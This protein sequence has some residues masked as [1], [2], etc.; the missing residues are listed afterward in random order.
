MDV[1]QEKC[2]SKQSKG[3]QKLQK[4]LAMMRQFLE[5]LNTT[6]KKYWKLGPHLALDE[7]KAK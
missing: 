3:G 6:I 2:I 7:S 1:H 4:K 5:Y